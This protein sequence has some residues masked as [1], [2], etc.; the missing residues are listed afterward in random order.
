MR[1]TTAYFATALAIAVFAVAVPGSEPLV[2][3]VNSRAEVL[4]G[5]ARGVSIDQDGA[6]TVAPRVTEMFK[7][8]ESYIWSSAADAAGNIYLGTGGQGKIFRVDAAGKGTLFA[9]LPDMNVSAL[10]I[11]RGGELYA[12]TLPDGKVYRIDAAGKP[13]VYF[14]PGQKYIWALAAGSD[15]LYVAT[16]DGGKL[17]KVRSAGAAAD[18]SLVFDSSETHIISLALGTKGELYAGTDPGGLVI[19]FGPDGKAFGVLDS[20]LRE[21]HEVIAAADG[22]VY[23]LAL[24][25]SVSAAKATDGAASAATEQK[26]V[27]VDKPN[28]LNPEP[29]PKS[30]YDLS[31]ARSAVYRVA[32]DSGNV[33]I[34]WSSGSVAGFSLTETRGG[35]LIGTSDKGRIYRIGNDA[36]ETLIAQTGAAQLST[37]SSVRGVLM[38]GSSNQG[39]LYRI[40]AEPPAEGTYDSAVLDSRG[41]SAWGRIWSTSSGNVSLQTRSGNSERPDETW[42][43]WSQAI[44][45]PKGGPVA[46]PKA[47]YLQWRAVLKGDARLSEV[48]I[49]FVTANIAPEV[50][51]LSVL[52]V[53][54]GLAANPAVQIDPNIET[55]GMDPVLFGLPNQPVP[56]R[57]LFQKGAISLQW[58][59]E[60]RNGDK[61]VFDVYYREASESQFKLLQADLRDAFYVVDGLSFADGRYVFKVT[62]RDAPSN[63]APAVMSGERVTDVISIDNSPPV[64]TPVGNPAVTGDKVRLVFDASDAGS[65]IT[66]AEYSINGGEWRV[67]YPDDG[68]SDSP[69]ERYTVDVNGLAPGEYSVTLRVFDANANPGLG[70]LSFKK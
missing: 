35:V 22:S 51:S 50:L 15:G 2:W 14:D 70:R 45:D 18:V 63:P 43:N 66:R 17:Y 34:L 30:R 68:I 39:S 7:T 60:D 10:A 27:T 32:P 56:P 67:V 42:S 6:I 44:S 55:A 41:S 37:L 31:S 29:A 58:T 12:A 69:R 13:E 26:P 57:R 52:P 46:S 5:D 24:G 19:R 25:E 59:A 9:D 54:V 53:N 64:V 23:T 3:T 21:I 4:R 16:G 40:A 20:P 36:R 28:P 61:L 38:A 47:R 49:A 65:Y 33:E 1:T 48:N 11:G 8:G 62:A